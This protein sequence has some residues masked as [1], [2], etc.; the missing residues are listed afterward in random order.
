MAGIYIHIP[1]CKQKCHY[2]N[3]H[4]STSLQT[5]NAVL[6][7]ILQEIEM[8]KHYLEQEPLD[9]IYF[10]GGTPSILSRD[11]INA[12]LKKV[13]KFFTINSRA[14]ITLEANPDDLSLEK[15]KHFK[16]ETS[17]NRLSIG[18]QSFFDEDLKFM[19]RAHNCAEGKAAIDNALEL[20]FNL[21]VDLIYGTPTLSDE[22][23]LQN[24]KELTDRK[25]PHISCYALTVEEGTALSSHIKKG[26]TPPL[27][28]DKA[29][30]QFNLLIQ[31]A[32]TKDYLHYEIS[33]FCLP[34]NFAVHNS[35]YWKGKKYLGIGPSAHSFNGKSRQWNISNNISYFKSIEKGEFPSEVE[36]LTKE[37]QYNEYLLTGLRTIW[38]V[39]LLFI[40]AN[41]GEDILNYFENQ[42]QVHIKKGH[43]LIAENKAQLTDSGKL[44]AD[45]IIADLF[46]D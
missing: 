44:L 5:K 32:K 35:N 9:S 29:A 13:D 42:T 15:L 27:D 10:G 8:Q 45:N 39:D 1:F 11:E 22:Q 43:L 30:N 38:G 20:G 18:L 36:E 23:W 31:A 33:N 2:C 6:D 14:E 46:L 41:F 17:I 19:N 12:I 3:F 37:Q 40:S 28:E 7:A 34:G 16:N 21:S 26:K 4:F 24:I 25:I